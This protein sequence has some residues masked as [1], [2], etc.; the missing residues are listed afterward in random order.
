MKKTNGYITSLSNGE[1]VGSKIRIDGYVENKLY[2]KDIW[3]VHRRIKGGQFWPKEPKVTIEKNNTFSLSTFEGGAPGMIN[4]SLIQT[5]KVISEMFNKWLIEGHKNN[6]FPGIDPN[7]KGI[8]ELDSVDVFYD[9]KR[10][11]KLFYSY[12]HKDEGHIEK[13]EEHLSTLKREGYLSSWF[14]R[15][16]SAGSNFSEIISKE[17]TTCDI[18]LM[19]ISSS[20]IASDYC[21]NI[22]LRKAME[23]H[24][25]GEAVVIPIIVRP[26]DW[27]NTEF[28]KLLALPKDGKPITK[29]D[30]ID[31]AWLNVV[32]GIRKVVNEIR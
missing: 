8:F 11:L 31:E 10:P 27:K 28:G 6:H 19:L 5:D 15:Q 9:N 20:F 16:I 2:E 17:I 12:S 1:K 32:T 21:F 23:R 3:I 29:W 30:N 7:I 14:D 4:I 18:I 25:I 24:Y 26:T 22:E 13:L